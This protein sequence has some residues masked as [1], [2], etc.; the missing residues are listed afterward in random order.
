MNQKLVIFDFDGVIIDSFKTVFDITRLERPTLTEQAYRKLFEGNINDVKNLS[1]SS[2]KIDFFDIYSKKAAS[3]L[4]I[5]GVVEQIKKISDYYDLT[6]VSSTTTPIIDNFL[7]QHDLRDYFKE[8]L[9][10]DVAFSKVT[11][12]KMLFKQYQILNTDAVYI[13]DTLG[14]IREATQVNLPCIAV[15]WGFHD[16]DLLRSGSPAR[17]IN[18]PK[19]LVPKVF[20]ILA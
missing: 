20:E 5:P 12:F 14:D 6:I 2:Q 7:K 13:T 8:I 11:K 9:G 16:E 4:L 3:L 1:P 19:E 15:T 10:N 17:L 18:N